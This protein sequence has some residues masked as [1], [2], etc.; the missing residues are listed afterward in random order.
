MHGSKLGY[1]EWAIAICPVTGGLSRVPT[2]VYREFP[3]GSGS[4]SVLGHLGAPHPRRTRP[5]FS[6]PCFDCSSCKEVAD[7]RWHRRHP[8]SC[9][10]LP[11]AHEVG[12]APSSGIGQGGL[13]NGTP[14]SHTAPSPFRHGVECGASCLLLLCSP[15]PSSLLALRLIGGLYL[16]MAAGKL[17][18]RH[19]P[20]N[21]HWVGAD[22]CI[23]VVLLYGRPL[24][25]V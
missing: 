23:D 15:Y 6:S 13:R 19:G 4:P 10:P 11:E 7:S 22:G 9:G 16:S 25:R 24:R 14:E 5:L 18:P 8:A 20:G 3:I 21:L 17:T 12:T 1:R 2:R